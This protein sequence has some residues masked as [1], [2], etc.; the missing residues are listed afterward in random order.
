MPNPICITCS[1]EMKFKKNKV[2]VK[3][4]TT[5]NT[6]PSTYQEGDGFQC[7]ECGCAIIVGFSEPLD[8]GMVELPH[9]AFEYEH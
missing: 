6:F 7:L 8:V 2:L 4:K 9:T 1:R 5:N 3:D